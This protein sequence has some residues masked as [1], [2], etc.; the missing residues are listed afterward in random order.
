LSRFFESDRFA[1]GAKTQIDADLDF[2]GA[3]PLYMFLFI[4]TGRFTSL[5]VDGW[6]IG[7]HSL[8]N[9][10]LIQ[11]V[12]NIAFTALMIGSVIVILAQAIT[13]WV[14]V[15]SGAPARVAEVE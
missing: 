11:S 8:A 5:V 6:T 1:V 14:N 15:A 9:P 10:T 13:R 2:I 12:L 7:N 4:H 3:R